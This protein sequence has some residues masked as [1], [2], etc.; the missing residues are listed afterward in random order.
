MNSP[1]I[2]FFGTSQFAVPVLEKLTEKNY[3][4]V[5][6]VARPDKPA[7]RKQKITPPP[8]KE[9]AAKLNF[10]LSQPEKASSI[11]SEISE[12]SPDI[13]IVAA[14]G[15]ILPN[16][17]LNTP[18]YG[19][20]NLHPSLLPKHRGPSPIQTAILKGDEKTGLTIIKMDEEMDHGPIVCQKEMDILPNDNYQTLEKKL[21]QLAAN[22]LTEVIPQ[23]ISGKI[24]PKKQNE[25]EATYTKMLRKED[26][27]INW[28]KPAQEIERKTR[29]FSLWPGTWTY[30]NN[31]RVKIISAKV[32]KAKKDIDKNELIFPAGKDFLL[33]EV[34]QPAGKKP[35][36]GQEFLRGNQQLKE[37]IST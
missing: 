20:L 32:I 5:R 34:V 16:N 24:K 12:L 27:Q 28:Q 37:N 18:A 35:M 6:V 11:K 26:G 19:S 21:S 8:I 13:I 15:Q 3:K 31:K 1:K 7:G 14:Y 17:I 23:Y 25:K 10:P 4:I 36:S 29:A 30:L 9:T 33:L 22:C 2:V